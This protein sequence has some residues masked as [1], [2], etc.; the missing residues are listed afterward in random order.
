[1]VMVVTK[2]LAGGTEEDHTY[3]AVSHVMVDI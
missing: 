2:H 3:L 1:M